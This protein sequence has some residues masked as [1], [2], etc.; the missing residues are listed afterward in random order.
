[1]ERRAGP[2]NDGRAG[3]SGRPEQQATGDLEDLDQYGYGE[4]DPATGV[5]SNY[6][7][8]AGHP[9]NRLEEGPGKTIGWDSI[10][11]QWPLIV[12]DFASEYSI[13]LPGVSMRWPEFDWLVSGLFAADTRL[14]RH[15]FP[16]KRDPNDEPEEG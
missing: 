7:V 6:E 16:P 9:A 12:A 5:W 4:K 2:G 11:E 1:M 13:R 15:F 10:V 3:G 8:P 14:Y